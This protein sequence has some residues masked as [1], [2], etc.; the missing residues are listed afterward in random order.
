MARAKALLQAA[1]QGEKVGRP[2]KAEAEFLSAQIHFM[3]GKNAKAAE[4]YERVSRQY[5]SVN[6]MAFRCV[7][8]SQVIKSLVDIP[9]MP[10]DRKLYLNEAASRRERMQLAYLADRI[11]EDYFRRG[12]PAGF[13]PIENLEDALVDFLKEE[14]L[15]GQAKAAA[16]LEASLQR[17][18]SNTFEHRYL[19][20]LLKRYR[21]EKRI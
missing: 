6:G 16:W 4:I 3:E 9:V 15:N 19:E 18:P 13:G 5:S 1:P 20:F 10:M 8:H 14:A 11:S 2:L 21:E 17:F 12:I 7:L